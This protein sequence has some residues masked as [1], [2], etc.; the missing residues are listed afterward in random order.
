MEALILVAQQHPDAAIMMFG[1]GPTRRSAER[2]ITEAGL[3]HRIQ[4]SGYTSQLTTWMARATVCVSVSL[5]EGHSNVIMEA[6]AIGCPLVLSDIPAHRELFDESNALM[7]PA[8]SP[9]RI[10]D[11]VLEALRNPIQAR[12]RAQRARAIALLFDLPTVA[13][14]YKSIYEAIAERVY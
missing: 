4:I 8:D 9:S 7:A 13:A 12:E 6:A 10:A 1:E 14:T 11:A 5:F 3:G 2:R